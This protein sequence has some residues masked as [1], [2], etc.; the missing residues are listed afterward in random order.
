MSPPPS[1]PAAGYTAVNATSTTGVATVIPTILH[2][3]QCT[4]PHFVVTC[5]L[6]STMQAASFCRYAK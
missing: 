5:L 6:S 2:F 1:P 3:M 4:F